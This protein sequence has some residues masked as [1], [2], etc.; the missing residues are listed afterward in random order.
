MRRRIPCR[1]FW[2]T[3]IVIFII[4]LTRLYFSLTD[5]IRI[6]NMVY[7]LPHHN[8]WDIPELSFE[9]K[10]HLASILSQKFHYLGK[11]AQSYVFSSADHQY[12]LKFFK[13]K[14][15]KPNWLTDILP[16][17]FPFV[18]YRDHEIS[19]KQKKLHAVFAGYHLAYEIHKTQSALI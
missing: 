2:V 1:F 9:E 15:L 19:R 13:F 10:I 4:L 3:G 16:A 5:D 8:E 11:G 18:H 6:G 12:V 17:I 14:H 7:D